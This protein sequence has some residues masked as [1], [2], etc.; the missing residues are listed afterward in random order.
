MARF[1][2]FV[3]KSSL[4][5]YLSSVPREISYDVYCILVPQT[6]Q[7]AARNV[8]VNRVNLTRFWP[9]PEDVSL[10]LCRSRAAGALRN[11]IGRDQEKPLCRSS[12]TKSLPR[13]SEGSD[14][15]HRGIASGGILDGTSSED[16]T[17]PIQSPVFLAVIQGGGFQPAAITAVDWT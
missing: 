13:S 17:M 11:V 3:A 14:L 5:A 15:Y 7:V 10:C 9:S 8:F 4:N 2:V 6:A 1:S 16:N 12:H